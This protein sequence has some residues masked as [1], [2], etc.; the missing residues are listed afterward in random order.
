MG[1]QPGMR[2]PVALGMDD[3]TARIWISLGYQYPVMEKILK[4]WK[5]VSIHLIL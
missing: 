1:S 4:M 5:A 2:Q 3:E